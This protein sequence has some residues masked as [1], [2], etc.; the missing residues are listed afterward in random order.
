MGVRGFGVIKDGLW[1]METEPMRWFE[2]DVWIA[3]LEGFEEGREVIGAFLHKCIRHRL[4]IR[5][6]AWLGVFLEEAS[7]LAAIV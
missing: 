7:W 4:Q 3:G 5:K 2:Y 6:G 1:R